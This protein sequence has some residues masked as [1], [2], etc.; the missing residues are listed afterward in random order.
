M[1]E[2]EHDASL[3]EPDRCPRTAIATPMTTA[4]RATAAPYPKIW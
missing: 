4:G 3:D 1:R 2:R